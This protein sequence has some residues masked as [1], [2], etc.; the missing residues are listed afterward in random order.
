M[1]T[2]LPPRAPRVVL[3]R[4]TRKTL[5]LLTDAGSI[6]PVKGM[7]MR[8]WRLKPSSVLST[9]MSAQSLRNVAQFGLGRLTRTPVRWVRSRTVN[10]SLGNGRPDGDEPSKRTR[11]PAA[12]AAEG[13]RTSR[14]NVRGSKRL[15][16]VI[17]VSSGGGGGPPGGSATERAGGLARVAAWGQKTGT[18]GEGGPD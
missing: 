9:S 2:T 14:A 3:P 17:G 1:P 4:L 11:T 18:G 10:T 5:L 16:D 12:S 8:G 6:G 15:N 13:S 7:E